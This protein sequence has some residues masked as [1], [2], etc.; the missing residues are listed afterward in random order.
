MAVLCFA[1]LLGGVATQ[2]FGAAEE[3]V[4]NAPL[5]EVNYRN[6][7]GVMPLVTDP[8]RVYQI[9]VNGDERLYYR[10]DTAALNNALRAFAAVKAPAREVMLRPGPAEIDTFD[11]TSVPYGWQLHLPGG[12]LREKAAKERGTKVFEQHP[13]MTVLV[14]GEKID[15]ERI[16]FPKSVTVLE[17]GD[18]R[19]RYLEGLTSK[20]DDVRGY[21]AHFLGQIDFLNKDNV[22]PI[23][24]LLD[25]ESDWVRLM[26]AGALREFGK[27]ASD[28]LPRLEKGLNDDSERIRD[29]FR[30]T[31]DVIQ[32]GDD[33]TAAVRQHRTA[34][35]RIRQSLERRRTNVL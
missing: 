14:G 23:S 31:I 11:G 12:R 30:E 15:L 6:F 2:G 10:G 8:N 24:Q 32:N 21:A 22:A 35:E 34:V 20:D 33:A 5:H 16:R 7:G 3:T 9:W 4:G 26:A 29:R 28:A 13:T 18:L 1:L 25:D 27:S 19:G 17:L